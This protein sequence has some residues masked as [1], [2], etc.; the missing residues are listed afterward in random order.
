M[1]KYFALASAPLALVLAACGSSDDAA[2]TA[3]DGGAARAETVAATMG[4]LDDEEL[5][6]AD[7]DYAMNSQIALAKAGYSEDMDDEND[8]GPADETPEQFAIYV[9]SK[10]E[11]AA[12]FAKA[13]VDPARMHRATSMVA[14]AALGG[15]FARNAGKTEDLPQPAAFYLAHRK[16]IKKRFEELEQLAR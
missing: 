5:T 13:D 15:E 8:E 1:T 7:V 12:I 3:A 10:P 14:A 16:E 2:G 11:L 4:E 6:M 9:K